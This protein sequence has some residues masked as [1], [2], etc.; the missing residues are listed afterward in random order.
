MLKYIGV[1]LGICIFLLLHLH[2]CEIQSNIST[3]ILTEKKHNEILM[4]NCDI[5]QRKINKNGDNYNLD[6]V[7]EMGIISGEDIICVGRII[8]DN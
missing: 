7:G 6:I 4:R 3:I 1:R 2:G 8:Y 5:R